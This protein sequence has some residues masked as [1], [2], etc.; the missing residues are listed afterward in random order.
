MKLVQLDHKF[1]YE[2]HHEFDLYESLRLGRFCL[3]TPQKANLI[4]HEQRLLEA[5]QAEE[6]SEL[7]RT[8]THCNA[9]QRTATRCNALQSTTT[10]CNALQ[11]TATH[12]DT[13][14]I[15]TTQ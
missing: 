1:Y 5:R 8:A 7:R 6:L 13:L 2:M 15:T 11:H 10:H 4:A 14:Q 3:N 12:C 9:L